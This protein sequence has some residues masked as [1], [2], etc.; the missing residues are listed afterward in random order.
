MSTS[1]GKKD[2]KLC[3]I[4]TRLYDKLM[5]EDIA[6][7]KLALEACYTIANVCNVRNSY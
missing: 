3:I 5:V 6:V 1:G 2:G 4:F 7:D